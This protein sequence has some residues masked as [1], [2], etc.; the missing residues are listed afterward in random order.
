M[1]YKVYRLRP[2]RRYRGHYDDVRDAV[3][4]A[5]MC[6]NE[7]REGDFG[8]PRGAEVW[9]DVP[10]FPD[11]VLLGTLARHKVGRG[12]PFTWDRDP[13]VIMKEIVAPLLQVV[14][15]PIT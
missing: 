2:D 15:V 6:C 11:S 14:G 5:E 13:Q 1:K 10:G 9:L 12:N 4:E 7:R 3:N 8:K